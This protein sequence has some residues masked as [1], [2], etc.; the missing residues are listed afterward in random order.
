M[1]ATVLAILAG[2]CWGV[3][4]VFAK[5]V[6]HTKAVGP[7]TAITIRTTVALPL[8]WIAY[9]VVVHGLKAEPADWY[10]RA[11]TATLL[12]LVLGAGVVA[13]T[14][15]ML[16]FYGA[17][18][19]GEISRIKP[20]AFALAPAVAVLLGW[21]VLGEA[22]TLRKAAAVGLILAGVVLLTSG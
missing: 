4:E 18:H 12:K 6:L 15:A 20:I 10:R 8:L 7:I 2:L 3:G 14:L 21:L 11:D 17:L 13:G 9:F 19:L 1:Q 5:S 16:A 22:M